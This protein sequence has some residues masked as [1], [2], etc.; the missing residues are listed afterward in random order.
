MIGQFSCNC[1][2]SKKQTPS[3]VCRVRTCGEHINFARPQGRWAVNKA[4]NSLPVSRASV[5]PRSV[6]AM[7]WSGV[8]RYTAL[9]LVVAL[10]SLCP[11]RIKTNLFGNRRR[12]RVRRRR[13]FVSHRMPSAPTANN[14]AT[15]TC[16]GTFGIFIP[17]NL[18]IKNAR[19]SLLKLQ[20]PLR[21]R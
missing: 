20:E 14:N 11:C 15:F 13:E 8:L 12:K 6:R 10:P 9:V 18:L 1:Q 16:D 19:P 4:P 2:S 7:R 17:A 21:G 3:S 5:L